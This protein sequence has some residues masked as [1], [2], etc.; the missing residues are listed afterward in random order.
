MLLFSIM[1]MLFTGGIGLQ[2]QPV[3]PAVLAAA[4]SA[5]QN[6]NRD[7]PAFIRQVHPQFGLTYYESARTVNAGRALSKGRLLASWES[8]KP[9]IDILSDYDAEKGKY[10]N[11]AAAFL[12]GIA[13]KHDFLQTDD[14]RYNIKGL[15]NSTDLFRAAKPGESLVS[16]HVNETGNELGW[17]CLVLRLRMLNGKY[18]ISGIDYLYWTP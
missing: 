2:A 13:A 15:T 7:F 1:T 5:L 14:V 16:F 4:R 17:S 3:P 8:E 6:I 10:V 18:C 9:D 12:R 11:N